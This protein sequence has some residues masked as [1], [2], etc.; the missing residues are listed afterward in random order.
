MASVHAVAARL[1]DILT[2][3]R[4]IRDIKLDTGPTEPF[5][6]PLDAAMIRSLQAA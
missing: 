4:T 2:L 6:R 5:G 3:I 1:V